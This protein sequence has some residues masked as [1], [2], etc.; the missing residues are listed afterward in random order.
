MK[1]NSISLQNIGP[2]KNTQVE[3]KDP[4]IAITGANGSG[5]SFLI[6]A[7]VACL[8]G[9]FPSRPG[10]IYDRITQGF[11]GEAEIKIG[12]EM[13]GSYYEALRKLKRTGKS[14]SAQGYLTIYFQNV[15][16]PGGREETIAGPKITDYEQA[17]INLLG[18]QDVFLASVFSSQ[19]N[20]GDICSARPS[21]RKAVF[22]Q[23]LGLGR[24]DRLSAAAKDKARE[25]E[26]GVQAQELVIKGLRERAMG[27]G[28]ALMD[29]TTAEGQLAGLKGNIETQR[30]KVAELEAK[31]KAGEIA[32]EKWRQ[33]DGQVKKLDEEIRRLETEVEGDRT[34]YKRL[35]AILDRAPEI[36]EAEEDLKRM[37]DERDCWQE[38][39]QQIE[40]KNHE[41][42]LAHEKALSEHRLAKADADEK[43]RE[44]SRLNNQAAL[45]KQ[46]PEQECCRG[47]SL[48]AEAVRAKDKVKSAEAAFKIAEIKVHE[49]NKN[50]QPLELE[51]T[52]GIKMNLMRCINEINELKKL[53]ADAPK[54]REAQGRMS[55][56]VES[57]KAKNETIEAK[58]EERENLLS[59]T[60]SKERIDLLDRI[61]TMAFGLG[62][63]KELQN[64]TEIELSE[65]TSQIGALKERITS[66]EQAEKEAAVAEVGIAGI[67]QEAEDCRAIE[68]AFGRSGIQPLIIEQA[69]PELETIADELLGEATG[70]R[71][72][73]RFETQKELKTGEMAESL[74]IIITMD[75]NERKIEEF[76]GGE[77]KLIR[78]AVRLTLAIWQ[79]R[80]GGSRLKTLF[81]DEVADALDGENSER[82]LKL[83]GS[84][85][86]QFER[87][88]IISHD[89]DLLEELPVRINIKK[90]MI[91][92]Q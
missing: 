73:V 57:G 76:S 2:H 41:K 1:I 6:E 20:S 18:P 80:R 71:M 92:N 32:L 35:K 91:E 64:K 72:R 65:L 62:V 82:V 42:R 40:N 70:G 49:L 66:M 43:E 27:V 52:D 26:T 77:Q 84:L 10:S 60:E 24:Y 12:F 68:Q 61:S 89:D 85:T 13:H 83:L 46:T 74:D 36:E 16:D 58:K 75:G 31:I 3:F 88:F 4:I 39:L 7:V 45:L 63:G 29:L 51:D 55:A 78:T 19:G 53:T 23:L 81:I 48:V 5:K 28:M 34:E 8:Y 30:A 14:T 17:I 15:S 9:D 44:L 37:T 69:R 86:N 22:A 67:K 56:M 25:L 50:I 11:E 33:L 54:L 87:I 21:E 38:Q 90:G 47:C 79:A 59:Q